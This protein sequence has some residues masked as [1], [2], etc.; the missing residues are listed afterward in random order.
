MLVRTFDKRLSA[1][2]SGE[3]LR[4]RI[5]RAVFEWLMEHAPDV[6]KLVRRDI[7]EEPVFLFD[8]YGDEREVTAWIFPQLTSDPRL[9]LVRVC[10]FGT[11][12]QVIQVFQQILTDQEKLRLPWS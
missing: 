9:W 7:P 6:L 5:G 1:Q 12:D 2:P 10:G 8:A 4:L 3:I 11:S